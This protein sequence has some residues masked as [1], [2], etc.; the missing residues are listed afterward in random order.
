MENAPEIRL[1]RSSPGGPVSFDEHG[2][3]AF[4]PVTRP[5]GESADNSRIA[6]R[7][8]LEAIR[9]FI[10]NHWS[11]IREIVCED[12]LGAAQIHHVDI[13]AEKHGSDYHPAR[14]RLHAMGKSR[15][16]VVN[17][18]LTDRGKQRLSRDF[19]LMESLR[20][21]FKRCFVPAVYLLGD[22]T[23]QQE[24]GHELQAKL[25]L[26]EWLERHWEFHV[27]MHDG[28]PGMI[29]WDM[30]R[31]YSTVTETDAE[32]VYRQAAFI[33]TY[34]YD[35]DSGEEIFPWHHAAGDFVVAG[36]GD[37]IEVRLITVRQYASR[38][39]FRGDSHP[40]RA[41]AL[42]L[43]LANLTIRMRL[44]R[45]DG[46]GDV[47]WLG[48]HCASGTIRGFLDALRE[49]AHESS[50]DDPTLEGFLRFL[51]GVSPAELAEIFQA[52]VESY[53]EEA[54]D[55]PAILEN[56]VDHILLT[57]RLIQQI[58]EPFIQ[59]GI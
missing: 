15:S 5:L 14:V 23:V 28:S 41:Q 53:D 57:H 1:M 47:A 40:D 18:A 8:Y 21:R 27:S 43:F 45:L 30:E 49:K 25:F 29:V 58:P 39:I 46:V 13:I 55:L 6:Y 7:T 34:Y 31:G 52:V 59:P 36:V 38:W 9:L 20:D 22:V 54:P 48:P 11:K 51:K 12:G 4:L 10:V 56:L 44:D 26:G 37:S 19:R 32:E 42:L 2:L 3:D 33:L 35:L 16:F 17:A 50:M 24:T